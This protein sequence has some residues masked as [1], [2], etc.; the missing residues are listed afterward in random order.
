MLPVFGKNDYIF[1][2]SS[3]S[4]ESIEFWP[5]RSRPR[6]EIRWGIRI[7]FQ[8]ICCSLLLVL[9]SSRTKN[10]LKS[11]SNSVILLQVGTRKP[12]NDARNGFYAPIC[13]RNDGRMCCGVNFGDDHFHDFPTCFGSHN[14]LTAP[15]CS[16]G[17]A[18]MSRN[19]QKIFWYFFWI[20]HRISL[21]WHGQIGHNS[22]VSR[23]NPELKN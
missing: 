15:S 2:N 6:G 7:F 3:F 23:G 17:R 21:L 11:A 12:G 13:P 18:E 1:S 4:G 19:E 20:P 16:L 5:I 22:C 8:K 14:D 10:T 9:R